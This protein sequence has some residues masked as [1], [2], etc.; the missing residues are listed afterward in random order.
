LPAPAPELSSLYQTVSMRQ[1]PAPLLVGERANANGSKAFRERLLAD[2]L[3]G[4]LDIAREQEHGGAHIL[5][6]C[7]AYVGRD[8]R[9][10]MANLVPLLARNIRLPLSIDST[11]PTVIETALRLHGGR[12]LIN[13]INL[14][15]GEQRFHQIATLASSY[16]AALIALTIDETGMAMTKEAKLQVAERMIALAAEH[17]LKPADLLIDLL[18]FTVGSGDP[19]TRNA[20]VETLDAMAELKKRYPDVGTILGVSNVSFGLKPAARRILNSVFLHLAIERGL[21]AAIV[22]ARGILP[23]YRIGKERLDAATAL[24]LNDRSNGDPL[25]RYM[26]LFDGEEV[27]E[28]GG[29]GVGASTTP[30]SAEERLQ[31]AVVDGSRGGLEGLLNGL[32]EAGNS[33]VSI[34]N[35]ML[36]P[37]MKRVGEL[38]GAGQMQLPFV[39]QSAET[40]KAAVAHLEPH[41]EKT[42]SQSRGTLVI[43]TVKGDVHDIGKNLVDIIVSNNGYKVV[44]LGIKVPLEEMIAAVRQHDATALGMS[45]LLVKSTVVMLENLQEMARRGIKVPVLLGGAAL[46]REYVETTLRSA[47]GKN[48]H[49]CNDA[50]DGLGAMNSIVTKEGSSVGLGE[51][52]DPLTEP[53]STWSKS[54]AIPSPGTSTQ[55]VPE[56]TPVAPEVD[57]SVP[58]PEVDSYETR[59]IRNIPLGE[60]FALLNE[61]TLFRGQWRYRRG[62]LSAEAYATLVREQVRPALE[63]LKSEMV[64]SGV[65]VPQAVYR[66]VRCHAHG[67]TTF[68]EGVDGRPLG[69][70][71]FPRQGPAPHRCISDYFRRRGTGKS[72]VLGLFVVTVGAD[73][74]REVQ[75]LFKVNRYRDYLHLHGLAVET[76]EATAEWLHLQMRR[77]MG[78]A[79][80]LARSEQVNGNVAGATVALEGQALVRQGYRGSRYSFGYP[81]CPDLDDQRTL[82]RLLEPSAI[83]VELSE[84]CQMVPEYSVSAVVVHHPDAKYFAV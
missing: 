9:A 37:A 78:I 22:N 79:P 31:K 56:E 23:V 62:T 73:V 54:L 36:I 76:A 33:P 29:E 7:V 46:T 3:Q 49:Y 35:E 60:V 4:M 25:M 24:L 43:A 44:N 30:L 32:L 69:R 2:D 8:E 20:A 57:Y 1:V 39:L 13:S 10:D 82:F 80:E 72:D 18:T 66:Y 65:M 12:C 40:M 42:D 52:E 50:F 63:A 74:A 51:E 45:G 67:N 26:A 59:V 71:D 68:L 28:A 41:M 14:E 21:D 6:V 17:G 38:F 58:V 77:E 53:R 19:A 84:T 15:D 11:D 16:G 34:I 47:Y 81:A 27:G 70:F 55:L 75:R 48:V 64:S 5:D 83:G 61:T